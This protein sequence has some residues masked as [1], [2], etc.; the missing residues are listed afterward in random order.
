MADEPTVGLDPASAAEMSHI[1]REFCQAGHAI[2]ISTHLLNMAQE[3]CDTVV[4]MSK[5]R[6][7]AEGS[8]QSLVDNAGDSLQELFLRL[9][10]EEDTGA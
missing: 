3:L 8:P 10:R 9:T 2:L 7:I 4:I 5:G 1:L 6:L